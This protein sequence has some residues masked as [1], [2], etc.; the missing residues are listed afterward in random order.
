M[1]VCWGLYAESEKYNYSNGCPLPGS[2]ITECQ[3][4]TNHSSFDHYLSF[5]DA[6]K[7]TLMTSF[8]NN[9]DCTTKNYTLNVD[10]CKSK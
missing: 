2:N 10:T 3:N 5:P 6:G 4:I 8:D 7:Y 1:T 9:A